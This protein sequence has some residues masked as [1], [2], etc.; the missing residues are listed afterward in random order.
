MNFEIPSAL[1]VALTISEENLPRKTDEEKTK[2]IEKISNIYRK[3]NPEEFENLKKELMGLEE[4]LHYDR[5]FCRYAGISY[6]HVD[7]HIKDI[8]AG[9]AICIQRKLF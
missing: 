3:K 8:R 2:I 4:N 7:E 6:T 1:E 5:Q 9:I